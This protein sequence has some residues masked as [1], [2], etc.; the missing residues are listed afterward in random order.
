ML[1]DEEISY[2]KALGDAG[3][4]M[5]GSYFSPKLKKAFAETAKL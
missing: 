2:L 4:R 1:C 5:E 3:I